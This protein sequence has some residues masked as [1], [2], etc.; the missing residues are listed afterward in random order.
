MMRARKHREVGFTF[1]E[2]MIGLSIFALVAVTIYQTLQG[3]IQM[4]HAGEGRMAYNQKLRLFYS[5]IDEDAASMVPFS[6]IT[7]EWAP[8]RIVFIAL[9][10]TSDTTMTQK[11]M[12]KITYS[13]DP[14]TRRL[15]RSSSTAGAGFNDANAV[16]KTMLDNVEGGNFSFCFFSDENG[17]EWRDA[18]QAADKSPRAVKVSVDLGNK[19]TNST[20]HI[21]KIVFIPTGEMG[22]PS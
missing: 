16:D 11:L 14:A 22:K 19:V 8:D 10:K 9:T 2:L 6:M 20:E 15:V 12:S 7:P 1:I 18:W 4:W 5:T 13:F 21:E 3:G 17:Y